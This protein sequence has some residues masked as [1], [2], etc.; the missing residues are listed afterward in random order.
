MYII[1]GHSFYVH[2]TTKLGT[3]GFCCID[4]TYICLDNTSIH[5]SAIC[6]WTT[7]IPY[8]YVF[9]RF[10]LL[11]YQKGDSSACWVHQR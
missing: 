3:L 1:R 7:S 9:F 6:I 8:I 5:P 10:F 4:R 11:S 2:M